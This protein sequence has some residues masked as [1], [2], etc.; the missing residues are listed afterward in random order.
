KDGDL[1]GP[2]TLEH[3]VDAVL[4]FDGD[5]RSGLRVLSGGKNRFG[6]EGE[7]A[8]FEMDG[9]GLVETDPSDHLAP[10]ATDPGAATTIVAAGRRAFAVEVQALV[11]ST[12][13]GPARRQASGL[14]PRRFALVTAVLDRAAGIPLVR[15]ELYGAAAGGL[16][17]DDP[18]SDLA[19]AAALASAA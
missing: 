2:R 11:V 19:V 12:E 17:I 4:A 7:V 5:P 9:S 6:P 16:R 3:A 8:W 18:A 10:R 13:G 1:A 15:A 14:D